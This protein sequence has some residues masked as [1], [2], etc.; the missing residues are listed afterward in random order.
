MAKKAATPPP[1]L[2]EVFREVA[3]A[4][5]RP[6]ADA[7]RWLN[8]QTGQST[9][10]S[11]YGQYERGEIQPTTSTLNLIL[12]TVLEQELTAAGVKPDAIHSVIARCQL[13]D[14]PKPKAKAKAKATRKRRVDSGTPK[15]RA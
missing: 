15:K 14:K 9:T 5:G 7:L 6:F 12:T 4:D 8:E 3:T 1:N 13:P 2:F 11:R 10:N